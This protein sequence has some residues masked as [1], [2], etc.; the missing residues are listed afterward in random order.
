MNSETLSGRRFVKFGVVGA[1]G[2]LVNTLVLFLG[3]EVAHMP[4][5]LA[6]M[7]AVETAVGNNFIWNNLWTFGQRSFTLDQF[8]KFN[9]VSLACMALTVAVLTTLV[10]WFGIHYLLANLLAV[11]VTTVW[12]FI[13]N[14]LWTWN[15]VS[16]Q[17]E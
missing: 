13:A 15:R 9:L 10:Q 11:G 3:Y 6:S 4:L 2:L 5:A 7:L 8:L 12:N 17:V 1:S 14:S 16:Q